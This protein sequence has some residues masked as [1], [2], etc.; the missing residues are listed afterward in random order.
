MLVNVISTSLMI[1]MYL[2]TTA[3][4]PQQE[5]KTIIMAHGLDVNHSVHNAMV[6]L[7]KEL[8]TLSEG[9]LK[10]RIYPNQQLGSER[11]LLELL[12]IGSVGITKVSAA[13]L[14][15]F[16]PEYKVFGLPYVFKNRDHQFRVLDGRIGAQLLASGLPYQLRGL[17]FYDGGARSFYTRDQPILTTGDLKG[18]KIRTQESA[19]AIA[20]VNTLGGSATPISWGEL[21]TALQ[22]GTVDGAENNLPSFYL[23]RHFEVCRH[24]SFNEHTRVPDVLLTSTSF[25]NSLNEEEKKWFEI[26]SHKSALYQRKLWEESENEALEG[27]RLEGVTFY[28]PDQNQFAVKTSVL[29]DAFSKDSELNSVLEQIL[30]EGLE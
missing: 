24:Y 27:L 14:E 11:E 2:L 28:Y 4:G 22:Q 20:L 26:A 10:F 17:C 23:S 5:R 1:L 15:N 21:Y 8:D 19:S 18:M 25:W 30:N 3:C 12:Q 6:L 29:R 7:G 13:V 16:V 9:K